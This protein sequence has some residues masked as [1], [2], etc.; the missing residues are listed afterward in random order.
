MRCSTPNSVLS[1][2]VAPFMSDPFLFGVFWF[3]EQQKQTEADPFFSQQLLAFCR[4]YQLRVIV[5]SHSSGVS[6]LML[7]IK[8]D[9]G[10]LRPPALV[11]VMQVKQNTPSHALHLLCNGDSFMISNQCQVFLSVWLNVCMCARS[12][13]RSSFICFYL[14]E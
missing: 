3:K 1:Q 11:I 5:M 6:S 9:F 8:Y 2:Q 14:H 13:F 7:D 12:S 10:L 4:G